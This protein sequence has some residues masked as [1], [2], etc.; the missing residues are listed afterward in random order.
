MEIE[1]YR[2]GGRDAGEGIRTEEYGEMRDIG[3]G[4]RTGEYGGDERRRGKKG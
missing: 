1:E 2:R 3:E 4:I